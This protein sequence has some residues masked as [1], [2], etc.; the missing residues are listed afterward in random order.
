MI[1]REINLDGIC[2]LYYLLI[3]ADGIISEK[4]IKMG[5]LMCRH[6]GLGYDYLEKSIECYRTM[7]PDQLLHIALNALL[8]FPNQLQIRLLAWM[9]KIA[10]ADG[11]MSPEEWRLIFR[12]YKV[13]LKLSQTEIM[14]I[15]KQLPNE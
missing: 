11:F 14:E 1:N 5:K 7:R 9:I 10:N 2:A 3:A 13:E 6:E 4:E 15:Q 8:G 12:I